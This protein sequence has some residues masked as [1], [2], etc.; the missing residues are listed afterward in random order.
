MPTIRPLMAVTLQSTLQGMSPNFLQHPFGS[1]F[2]GFLIHKKC[3]LCKG[4]YKANSL[5]IFKEVERS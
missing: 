4:P 5:M 1:D 2:F 3:K